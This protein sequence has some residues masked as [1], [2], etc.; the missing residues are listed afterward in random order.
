MTTP[1]QSPPA[2]D[3]QRPGGL[4]YARLYIAVRAD[5]PPGLQLAQAVH[6]AF[7]FHHDHPDLV[8]PWIV[9]SNYLVVVAVPDEDALLDL[10]K[11]AATRGI[12]R[13]AVREPDLDDAA[14]AV[15][16]EPGRAARRL[17]AQL[18]LA[19]RPKPRPPVVEPPVVEQRAP[20]WKKVWRK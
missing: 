8:G 7:H 2:A 13:T 4:S 5:L 9:K 18:P 14:T 15:A 16:L 11:E 19:L 1:L 12:A 10:I 17:C 3:E 20:W 6:A